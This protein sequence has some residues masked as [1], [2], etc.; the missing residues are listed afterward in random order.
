M[1]RRTSLRAAALLVVGVAIFLGMAAGARAQPAG[2][3]DKSVKGPPKLVTRVYNVRDLIE[4]W[5]DYPYKGPW[6]EPDPVDNSPAVADDGFF[7]DNDHE[8]DRD[9]HGEFGRTED[10]LVLLK[11]VMEDA[12]EAKDWTATPTTIRSLGALLIVRQTEASHERIAQALAAI[13]QEIQTRRTVSVRARWVLLDGGQLA[14]VLGGKDKKLVAPHVVTDQALQQAKAVVAGRAATTGLDAQRVHVASG[15]LQAYLA[16]VEPVVAEGAVAVRPIIGYLLSGAVLEVKPI[17]SAD[18][19]FAVVNVHSTVADLQ[20]I[21]TVPMQLSKVG[22]FG[23]QTPESKGEG[24][25]AKYVQVPGAE[26]P[27]PGQ[28]DCPDLLM[29]TLRTTVTVPL[30]KLVL[31]A[32]MTAPAE[33]KKGTDGKVMYLILQV[34][35]SKG[36]AK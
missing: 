15:G 8:P 35:A 25:T 28:I 14:A 23:R 27:S 21:R 22:T 2:K 9:R 7:D 33:A 11:A 3:P 29:H 32:G 31:V 10:V 26:A 4:I 17:L 19:R 18:G 6:A 24:K 5:P 16:N 13:R 34:S 30:D 36:G 1:N 12:I 20:S